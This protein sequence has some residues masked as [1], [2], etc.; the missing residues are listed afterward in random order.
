MAPRDSGQEGDPA[1]ADDP[2][3]LLDQAWYLEPLGL[4][5]D[6]AAVLDRL[7]VV[8]AA[9][10]V[11]PPEG[12]NWQLEL[13]AERAVDTGRNMRL[14][15]GLELAES[16]LAAADDDLT[17]ARGR[18][19]LAAG[20]ALAWMATD[21]TVARADRAF[22]DAE[23]YFR[24][25]GNREWLG[26]ALLRRG[27][28]VWFQS[29]ADYRRAEA[30]IRAALSTWDP[31][32]L[33]RPPALAFHADVL[34]ELGD[35]DEAE[36][37]LDAAQA[38]VK[39]GTVT[40]GP[41]NIAWTRAHLTAARRDARRTERLLNEAER[42][43][44][45]L[46]WFEAHMGTTFLLDAAEL[47]SR[48]GLESRAQHYFERGRAR[49]G[50]DDAEVLQ[51]RAALLA[52]SGDPLEAIEVLQEMV[53]RDWLEKR[54]VW[55][56]DLLMAWATFRAGRQGAGQLAAVGLESAVRCGS[57]LVAL[58]G[59]PE[60]TWPLAALAEQA[61]SEIARGIRLQR[62]VH[63][64]PGQLIVRLFG[65]ARITRADG[66]SVA[67]P[68]GMP[69]ELAR[70]LALHDEGLPVEV[71]LDTFFPLVDASTARGRLR[72][73]LARLRTAAGDIVVRDEDHIRLVPC[74][75]DVR[76]FLAAADRARSATGALAVMRAYA[77]LALHSG[78]LLPADRYAPWAEHVRHR[79]DYRHLDLLEFLAADAER[80][81]SQVEALTALEAAWDANPDDAER[82]REAIERVR[83]AA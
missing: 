63:P 21:A 55:R 39:P 51:A 54:L 26:S 18:A 74:W 23:R 2:A 25:L 47:L 32:S 69:G 68:A 12:R 73:V 30:F 75:V 62:A 79:V 28:S 76:E 53:R 43:A 65:P 50:D 29:A 61:G 27:Y 67:I 49:A 17:V 19:C 22:A 7:E 46:D 16:V 3:V 66:T 72:Q 56:H 77:A 5:A 31:S 24:A 48:L 45:D 64:S 14:R 13:L 34:I 71:V 33:R 37:Q 4:Y 58:L 82:Y 57:P 42:E 8:L 80:R 81:G 44:A 78:P 35:L 52:R 70:M 11:P 36:R 59:E 6:R 41:S 20:Q 60:V 1:P 9:G 15:E 83:G 40:M 10:T 38:L